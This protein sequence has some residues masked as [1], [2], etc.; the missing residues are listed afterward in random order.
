MNKVQ[1]A[2][3]IRKI[4]RAA[5]HREPAQKFVTAGD[6]ACRGLM[7]EARPRRNAPSP[8]DRAILAWAEFDL[9]RELMGGFWEVRAA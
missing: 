8:S 5:V 3:G 7:R 9:S 6:R 4:I 2:R 1:R